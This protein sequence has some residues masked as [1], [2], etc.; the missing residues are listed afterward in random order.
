MYVN[1]FS[2]LLGGELYWFEL[3]S[4]EFGNVHIPY[5]KRYMEVSMDLPDTKHMEGNKE[6]SICLQLQE[7]LKGTSKRKFPFTLGWHKKLDVNKIC[8]IIRSTIHKI[9]SLARW[10]FFLLTNRPFSYSWYRTGTSLQVKLMQRVI[11]NAN[12]VIYVNFF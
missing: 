1:I 11:T 7:L 6:I 12:D 9:N 3:I 8:M 5:T 4:I 2:N 10:S